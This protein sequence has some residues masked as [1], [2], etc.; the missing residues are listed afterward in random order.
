MKEFCVD[1][2]SAAVRRG[3]KENPGWP[4]SPKR[5]NKKKLAQDRHS[6]AGVHTVN[7]ENKG[8]TCRGGL[9]LEDFLCCFKKIS[10]ARG[11][12]KTPKFIYQKLCIYYYKFKLQSPSKH[13][14][15][16]TIHLSRCF[17]HCSKQL[18]NSLILMPFCASAGFGFTCSHWQNVSKA[19]KTFFNRE[20]K[21]K[22]FRARLGE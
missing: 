1:I 15:F 20:T 13:S 9:I 11:D 14:P 18:L 22:S 2:F 10:Y 17:F 19:L 21:E 7:S 12:P 8:W 6:V 5:Q 4:G 16:D 3:V